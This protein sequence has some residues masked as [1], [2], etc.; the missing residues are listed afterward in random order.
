MIIYFND[1]AFLTI[2]STVQRMEMNI[3]EKNDA[4]YYTHQNIR[5]FQ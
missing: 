3:S 1:S 5:Q 2:S 4:K